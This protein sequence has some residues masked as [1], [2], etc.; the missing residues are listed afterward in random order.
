[1]SKI[2]ERTLDFF[3]AFAAARRPLSLTDLARILEIPASSCHD[4]I[5]A[6]EQRGYVYETAP[7]AGFYPTQKL[8]ELARVIAA[9]DSIA[10][11][12][13]PLME[14]IGAQL[15]ETVTLSKA[16]GTSAVYLL[17]VEPADPV[18][19]SVSPGSQIQSLHATS[20]GK[21]LLSTIADDAWPA[22]LG[23]PPLA[24]FTGRTIVSR[25]RLRADVASGRARG[26]FVN[27]EESRTGV[28]TLSVPFT[29][30]QGLHMLTIAGPADRMDAKRKL[31][32]TV[33]LATAE[34]LGDRA[35]I[36]TAGAA[37]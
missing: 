26:W 34:Q 11:R 16:S 25:S 21:S 3:E 24:R 12:A 18:R 37:G 22:Y 33:L 27:D 8:F 28:V 23:A 4:V 1:M 2:V 7:R 17:V 36:S 31:A 13:R 35:W 15:G 30:N 14:A 10:L 29:W 32:S 9:H 20:V 5:R 6:L 19:Y